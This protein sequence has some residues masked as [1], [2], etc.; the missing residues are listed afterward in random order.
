MLNHQFLE[1]DNSFQRV[2]IAS[3]PISVGHLVFL[4]TE[5]DEITTVLIILYNVFFTRL[6]ASCLFLIAHFRMILAVQNSVFIMRGKSV[7]M[8]YI[9]TRNPIPLFVYKRIKS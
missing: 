4:C 3:Q 8:K 9:F 7:V 2:G 6:S 1:K 5:N